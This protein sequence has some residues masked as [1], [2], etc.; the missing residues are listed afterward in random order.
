MQGDG[1]SAGEVLS[2]GIFAFQQNDYDAALDIANKGIARYSDDAVLHEFRALVLFARQ[3]YQQSAS[4]IY[5]VLAVGPGWDWTTLSSMYS[6]VAVY[7]E[8]LRTLEAFTKASP[9]DSA[10]RFLLAYYYMSCGHPDAA[11]RQLQQVVK[12]T[13]NDRVSA[14]LLK[15]MLAPEPGTEGET[16]SQQE[17]RSSRPVPPSIDPATLVGTWKA[18]RADGSKFDLTLTNDAKFTWSFTQKGQAAQGFGGAYTVEANV[19]ALERSN[20]GSLIAEITPG[21]AAKF[22]FKMLGAPADDPGLDFNR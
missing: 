12:L 6:S 16:T 19:L 7:T 9:Q 4:T 13:P 10:S 11:A 18:S 14:D 20:G 1:N 22:N 5:S 3:D 8:Q 2:N 15:M 17:S 21:G